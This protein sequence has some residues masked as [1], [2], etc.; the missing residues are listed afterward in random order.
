LAIAEMDH[1]LK[2]GQHIIFNHSIER[3]D[4]FTDM[5]ILKNIFINLLSNAIKF[6]AEDSEIE[7][8]MSLTEKN[9][10]LSVKDSGIGIPEADQGHLFDRFFR[11]GNAANIQGSGLGL[12]IIGKYL[13]LLQGTI[14]INS[15]LDKGSTFTINL[16]QPD[17][18]HA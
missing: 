15:Q 1:L 9:C 14:T 10:I 13:E 17:L 11:A 2:K 6:S 3:Q 16:P 18:I 4:F 12:H 8:K 5:H 7:I